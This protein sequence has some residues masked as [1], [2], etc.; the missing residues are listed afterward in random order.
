MV[1]K[2]EENKPLLPQ[3][4]SGYDIL[5]QQQKLLRQCGSSLEARLTCLNHHFGPAM[6][7]EP[8]KIHIAGG[9]GLTTH[10]YTIVPSA[11]WPSTSLGQNEIFPT[12]TILVSSSGTKQE[13]RGHFKQTLPK[14]FE[15]ERRQISE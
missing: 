5:S 15:S 8:D 3:V 7:Q 4:A 14:N 10:L 13:K 11:P 2:C 6:P 12:I 1:W 9:L